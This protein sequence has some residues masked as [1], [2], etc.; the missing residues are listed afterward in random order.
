MISNRFRFN[1]RKVDRI[2]AKAIA[3]SAAGNIRYFYSPD[4][5]TTKRL[6]GELAVTAIT[7]AARDAAR[8][9]LH[10]EQPSKAQDFAPIAENAGGSEAGTVATPAPLPV[11]HPVAERLRRKLAGRRADATGLITFAKSRLPAISLSPAVADRAI[12]LLDRLLTRAMAIGYEILERKEGLALKVDGEDLAL[13][14][15]ER[16][17]RVPHV[18]TPKEAADLQRWEADK[19][20]RQKNGTYYGDWGKP[21]VPETDQVPNGLLLFGIDEGDHR[22]DGLQRNFGDTRRRR[23]EDGLEAVL[24]GMAACAAARK[25]KRAADEAWERQWAEKER[26]RKDNER[27]ITLHKKRCEFLDLQME[28]LDR[29]LK[30]RAFVRDYQ[31]A[32]EEIP[33]PTASLVQFATLLANHLQKEIAPAALAPMLEKHDLMNDDA[34]VSSW[35]SF[36]DR[37]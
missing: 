21:R 20:I 11:L 32:F 16:L 29:A 13:R 34:E 30:L 18:L 24:A 10:K 28:R 27:R 9:K 7:V 8:D 15:S 33:E 36:K 6:I 31:A 17:D 37:Y 4:N 23:L 26:Q 14:L 12:R 2:R 1:P 5:G 35:I 25:E 3:T 19:L 22:H